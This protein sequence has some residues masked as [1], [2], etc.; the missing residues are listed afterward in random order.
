[1]FGYSKKLINMNDE[2]INDPDIIAIWLDTTD[3]TYN[4]WTNYATWLIAL[5]L[6][7]DE[8]LYHGIRDV[9]AAFDCL[10]GSLV[11]SWVLCKATKICPGLKEDISSHNINLNDVNWDEIARSIN[12]D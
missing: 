7:N 2:L 1:M 4:G 6:D 3:E 9:K 5:W 8:R 10:P 12:D 11:H